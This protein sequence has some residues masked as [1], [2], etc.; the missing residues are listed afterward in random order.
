MRV[1]TRRHDTY[2][3]LD[4]R[5]RAAAVVANDL[6]FSNVSV[7]VEVSRQTVADLDLV[8]VGRKAT[9]DA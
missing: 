7:L 1:Y 2:L 8:D 9:Y 6:D 3:A 5:A 4:K